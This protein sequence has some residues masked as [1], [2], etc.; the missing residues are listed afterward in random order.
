MWDV[1]GFSKAWFSSSP[2]KFTWCPGLFLQ[3]RSKTHLPLFF[4]WE[5]VVP[6][7]GTAGERAPG[8]ISVSVPSLL[9]I[10]SLP[11][12][13]VTFVNALLGPL[14]GGM[15]LCTSF[16]AVEG[17]WAHWSSPHSAVTPLQVFQLPHHP[18]PG[19]GGLLQIPQLV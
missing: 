16:G 8:T 12:D 17:N 2:P 1:E 14:G 10:E 4:S 19:R 15:D 6:D 7:L 9:L 18:L 5:V 3:P 11:R 13:T